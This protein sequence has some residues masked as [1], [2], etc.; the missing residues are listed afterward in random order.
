MSNNVNE[1]DFVKLIGEME[2]WRWIVMGG[3]VEVGVV[4]AVWDYKK[5]TN[6]I[7]TRFWRA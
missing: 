3:A 4:A 7:S 6:R 1:Q 5:C 2:L